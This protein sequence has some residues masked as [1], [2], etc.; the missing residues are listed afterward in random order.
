MPRNRSCPS[1]WGHLPRER[2]RAWGS[3]GR[4]IA[5]EQLDGIRDRVRLRRDQRGTVSSW[6]FHQLGQHLADKARQGGV[7]FVEVD[8]AYPSQRC[9]RCGH[10][11]RANRP[12]RDR[13]SCR[14]CGLSLT[15]DFARAGGTPTACRPRRR[16]QRPQPRALG[17]GVRPRTC[18][19]TCPRARPH[20]SLNRPER[21]APPAVTSPF[22]PGPSSISPTERSAGHHAR[23]RQMDREELAGMLRDQTT[24]CEPARAALLDGGAFVVWSAGVPSQQ[25][26]GIYAARLRRARKRGIDSR[27]VRRHRRHGSARQRGR[28]AW[29]CDGDSL[30][31]RFL[32]AFT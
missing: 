3:T 18:P 25:R 2:S 15:L 11:G 31:A 1:R 29:G 27:H 9:P 7:P 16:G 20:T 17:V 5:V 23:G 24:A 32:A 22:G 14:R 8:A 21:R 30:V 28:R 4:G 19:R 12:D 6:P 10:T 13:F 26:A